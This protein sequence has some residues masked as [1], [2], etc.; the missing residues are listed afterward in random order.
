[1]NIMK[2][3]KL[4]PHLVPGDLTAFLTAARSLGQHEGNILLH[5]ILAYSRYPTVLEDLA[6][7]L[8]ELPTQFTARTC[9]CPRE[10]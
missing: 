7:R 8:A 1:M 9:V 6:P 4:I 10:L 2:S 3:A 5:I